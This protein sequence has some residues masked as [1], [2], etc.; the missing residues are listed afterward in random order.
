MQRLNLC[1]K[2]VRDYHEIIEY[3]TPHLYLSLLAQTPAILDMTLHQFTALPKVVRFEDTTK[4]GDHSI[5][6]MTLHGHTGKI[7][8]VEFS[9]DGQYLVTASEDKTVRIWDTRTCSQVGDALTGH[10]D[11]VHSA[12]FSPDGKL[13]VSTSNSDGSV[14]IW[15]A[16]SK[17]HEQVGDP[18]TRHNG[19]EKALFLPNGKHV[20]SASNDMILFWDA[21]THTE[22]AHPLYNRG[23]AFAVSPNGNCIA[24]PI[25]DEHRTLEIRV[26][27]TGARIGQLLTGHW[28]LVTAVA[29]SPDGQHIATSA[30]FD[31]TLQ[32]WDVKTGALINVMDVTSDVNG[33]GH[34][35]F[36]LDGRYLMTSG[37]HN[38]RFWDMNTH[39][40]IQQGFSG[41]LSGLDFAAMSSNGDRV[42]SVSSD[43]STIQLW[44]FDPFADHLTR[45]TAQDIEL[46]SASYSPN[47]K[48][49]AAACDDYSVRIWDAE[50]C[51]Q[52]GSPLIGH[53][54]TVQSASFS[55]DGKLIVTASV[56][57][58]VRVWNAETGAQIGQPLT[59][60]TGPIVSASFSPD[61]TYLLSA[62]SS[63]IRVCSAGR[64]DLGKHI[65]TIKLTPAQTWWNDIQSVSFL[66]LGQLLVVDFSH[67][68]QL[69]DLS[70]G[71]EAVIVPPEYR[72]TVVCFSSDEHLMLFSGSEDGNLHLWN[73]ESC[74]IEKVFRGHTDAALKAS[75]SPDGKYIVSA[76]KDDTIRVWSTETGSQTAVYHNPGRFRNPGE[77]YSLKLKTIE[78]S[79]DG[80]RILSVYYNHKF[81]RGD[82]V[83]IWAMPDSLP[84][85]TDLHHSVDIDDPN[86]RM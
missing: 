4:A 6:Y 50:N 74:Q 15:N 28:G 2:F 8:S 71:S 40:Q 78:V 76:S 10:T 26:I 68:T 69:L 55:P 36:Y 64:C 20:T 13:V 70:T 51:S 32:T 25:E 54:D 82:H 77:F 42:A 47:G 29:F 84:P 53:T 66:P 35:A 79:L 37:W 34:I 3:A 33:I 61:G 80:R 49:I 52:V 21:M 1:L 60:H 41:E 44:S 83:Q 58:T 57:N 18:F 27:Q 16:Q 12:S 67:Y 75:F 22:I 30:Y 73:T 62:D 81:T 19:V 7:Y 65:R 85:G 23:L 11:A 86:V 14:R 24:I 17:A 31:P 72:G 5:N 63:T 45:T 48:H 38:V 39:S 46:T 9:R 43:H 59:G 56:D